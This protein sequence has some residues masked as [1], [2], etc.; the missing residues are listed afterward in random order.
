MLFAS[1]RPCDTRHSGQVHTRV[2]AAFWCY[3]SR[4]SFRD[5]D[6]P[7]LRQ[8]LGETPHI[9][10]QARFHRGRDPQRLVDANEVVPRHEDGDGGLKALLMEGTRLGGGERLSFVNMRTGQ[11]TGI[12]RFTLSEWIAQS[13]SRIETEPL[14]PANLAAGEDFH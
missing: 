3:L 12:R 5:F 14:S 9:I 2:I 4:L 7:M 8:K 13:T 6:S 1:R 11:D 10:D